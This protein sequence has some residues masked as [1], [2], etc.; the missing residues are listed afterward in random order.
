MELENAESILFESLLG[1]KLYKNK[2]VKNSVVNDWN[3]HGKTFLIGESV[4]A[5]IQDKVG[6]INVNLANHYLVT[7]G[8]VELGF[9]YQD[10]NKY[11]DALEDWK[12]RDSLSRLN[13]AEKG[14]Y[15]NKN[16]PRNGILQSNSEL[17]NI[18]GGEKLRSIKLDDF[19]TTELVSGFNP[20][21]APDEILSAYLNN[22]KFFKQVKELRD[23]GKLTPLLFYQITGVD[24]G[25]Y[26][27]F[28]TSGFL[29][30]ELTAFD[31]GIWLTKRIDLK[32]Q[33]KSVDRPI[34]IKS[35]SWKES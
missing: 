19:F 10:A 22:D 28:A 14:D 11:Y 3:F 25:E 17:I 35:V 5:V 20:L 27:T 24:S 7:N 8:L 6:L 16:Y 15:S 31:S 34:I 33:P 30:V 2:L 13:G 21:N 23:N 26:I 18:K 32:L 4:K 29:A 9:E 12:D 1:N